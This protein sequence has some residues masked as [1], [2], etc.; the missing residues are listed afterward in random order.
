VKQVRAFLETRV[1]PIITKYWI[2]DSVPFELLPA[3]KELNLGGVGLQGYGYRGGSGL[4][5]GLVAMEMARV[6]RDLP[7]CA[8]RPGNLFHLPR[9]FGRAKKEVAPACGSLR[10]DRLLRPYGTAGGFGSV[11]RS[12]NDGET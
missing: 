2:E 5:A 9:R 3:L 4:L 7:R 6:D 8:R 11:R 1:A 10:K 12:D